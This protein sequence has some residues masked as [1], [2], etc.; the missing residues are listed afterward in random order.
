MKNLFILLI[1]TLST[2]ASA[3]NFP[4]PDIGNTQSFPSLTKNL[5][6]EIVAY[7]IEKDE[8]DKSYL[9]YSISKDKGE[10]FSQKTLIYAD[11]NLS[12]SKLAKPKI[13]FKKDGSMVAVFS[14]KLG[15]PPP[16]AAK[17]N[18]DAHSGHSGGAQASAPPAP[19]SRRPSSIKFTTSTDGVRFSEPQWVDRD[20]TKLTRG[21]FDAIVLANDELAVS[22]LK[23]VK[24]P[25]MH[26][27]RDLRIAITKNGIFQQEIVLDSVVCHC[28]NISLLVEKNGTLNVYYR[29]NNKDIRDIGCITSIDNGI[30]FISKGIIHADKWELKGCPHTT[31]NSISLDSDSYIA[32]FSGSTYTKPGVRVFSKKGKMLTI[33]NE[34]SKNPV[35]SSD[36]KGINLSWEETSEAGQNVIMLGNITNGKF[37]NS[38]HAPIFGQNPVSFTMEDNVLVAYEAISED[39]KTEI[40][41]VLIKN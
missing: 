41:T 23:D 10:N 14:F 15:T 19:K 18:H 37:K 29:D 40:K 38:S 22:Y 6:G 24:G 5:K 16:P 11:I 33:L 26:E 13:L 36:G 1:L 30:S 28:C 35:F 25:K 32:W 27:E 21:F 34:S 7:W 39:K 4:K 17:V 3:A 20:T 8:F 9:Y 2:L 31:A 12:A